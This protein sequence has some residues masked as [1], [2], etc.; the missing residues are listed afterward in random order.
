MTFGLSQNEIRKRIKFIIFKLQI[1]FTKYPAQ[2]KTF[3]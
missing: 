3:A 2:P 1:F